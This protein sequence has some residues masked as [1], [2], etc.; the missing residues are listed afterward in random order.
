[1]ALKNPNIRSEILNA[2]L[3]KIKDWANNWKIKFNSEKTEL[4]TFKR[5]NLQD[6]PLT[7]D[8]STLSDIEHHKHLGLTI[9]NDCKWGTH[10]N[11]IVQKV[12]CLLSFLKS[13]KDRLLRKSLNQMYKAFILPHFD[14]ADIIYDNCTTGQ[15]ESLEKLHLEGIRIIIGA[16]KGTSHEKL[17]KESGYTTLKER[18]KRHKIIF[19]HKIVHNLCP[20]YLSDLCPQLVSQL[21]PYH[22]RRPYERRVPQSKT[23][24]YHNSFFPSATRLYNTLPDVVK[25]NPSISSLKHFLNQPDTLVP[26]YYSQGNRIPELHHTRLRLGIS[27]L[28]HDLFRRHLQADPAC[29]C[30]F[31]AETAEH[32]LLHCSQYHTHRQATINNLPHTDILTLLNGNTSLSNLENKVIFEIVQDFIELTE[33]L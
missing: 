2:D 32:F 10:I 14:Y 27:N 21:N 5:D 18:R 8:N 6:I 19:M 24:L 9:Q 30:G 26:I 22:R 13:Y 29:G 3:E 11:T 15:S 33:R 16:V 4:L 12:T 25:D 7:F 1:M 17:Y 23:E 31:A 28:N 20:G